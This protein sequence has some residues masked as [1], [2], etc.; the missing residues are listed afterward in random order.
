MGFSVDSKGLSLRV[1]GLSHGEPDGILDPGAPERP[2][3]MLIERSLYS[4]LLRQTE[5]MQECSRI[6]R[7]EGP[8]DPVMS[9]PYCF[10]G[11][12]EPES[13]WL[14]VM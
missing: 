12:L 10:L 14:I 8:I 5:G 11:C 13:S 7:A 2:S 6:P 9:E 3:G 4:N 1:P